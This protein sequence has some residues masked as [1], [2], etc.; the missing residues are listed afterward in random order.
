MEVLHWLHFLEP[1][2]GNIVT[3]GVIVSL[4]FTAHTVR[5]ETKTRRITNLLLITTNHREIW[6]E[7]L[8]NPKLARIKDSATDVSKQPVTD[9][10]R[11]Y[12][13]EIILHVSS[14]FYTSRDR[15]VVEYDEGLR[16]DIADFFSLPIPKAVWETTKQ[17]QNADFVK[18]MKGIL[19]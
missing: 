13:T 16:R 12:I 7:Y 17:F 6:M 14:V 2:E 19:N 4:L 1:F 5:G 3:L 10:E 11:I 18:F 9:A 8:N 15:L